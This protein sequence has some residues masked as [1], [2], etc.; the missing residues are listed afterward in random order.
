[1]DPRILVASI[2]RAN[3][4]PRQNVSKTRNR[5]PSSFAEG[6]A[7]AAFVREPAQPSA[8]LVIPD[9]QPPKTDFAEALA[10]ARKIHG[11]VAIR[12]IR[13]HLT[14]R[15][16]VAALS[17]AVREARRDPEAVRL[18]SIRSH[19]RAVRLEVRVTRLAVGRSPAKG[20]DQVARWANAAAYVAEPPNGDP[21]P[22]NWRAAVRYINRRGGMR[23]LSDLWSTRGTPEPPDDTARRPGGFYD[24]RRDPANEWYTSKFVFECLE[25]IFDLDPASPGARV[26]PWIPA[27]RHFTMYGLEREWY[28]FVWLNPQFGRD[29]LKYWIAKFIQHGNGI[30]LVPDRTSTMWWQQLADA[31][32]L[33]L[34]M[35][36]KIKFSNSQ[37]YTVGVFPIDTHLIAIGAQGVQGLL[38]G[39]RNGL[40]VLVK[41]Y[42]A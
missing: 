36:Y 24:I 9:W 30:C 23:R 6:A 38:N 4:G 41:P 42:R 28:G 12:E 11:R 13:S 14:A 15:L 37:G 25:C 3:K 31:A 39:H 26:V 16:F 34:C 22:P 10:L 2:D 40:G 17:I 32:D 1:M 5:S 7:E 8:A 35:R 33:I 27:A 20:Q 29:D 19:I 18:E 21:P